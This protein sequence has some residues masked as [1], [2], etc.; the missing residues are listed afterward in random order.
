VKLSVVILC[1]NDLKVLPDCLKSIYAGTH[2]TEFEVIVSDNGSEDGTADYV[3]ENFP[4]VRLIEN[5]ANLRFAKGNNV[6]I[7]VSRG[8]YV[9]ILNPDTII[10]DGALDEMVAYAER[11][12][13]GGAF[14]CRVVNEDGSYQEHVRPL[15]TIRSEWMLTLR[16]G[17]LARFSDWF[18]PGVYVGWNG[19]GERSA[20]QVAG[21]F[22]V[23]RGELLK[24]LGGF[25]E[26]FFYYYE[27]TD[28]C[29]RVWEAGY[30]ILYA[31]DIRITH[32][33]G[34]S[35]K[36]R[37]PLGFTLDRYVTKYRYFYKLEGKRGAE[38]CRRVCLAWLLTRRAGLGLKQLIAPNEDRKLRLEMYKVATEWNWRVD[39]VRL[40]EHG[41]EPEL[42]VQATGR[43]LER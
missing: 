5:G 43:V 24:K 27:D 9:L 13:E 29:R 17:A 25:D 40:V 7:R 31:P 22:L 38:R 15:P 28:L 23:V 32:L 14:S 2:K 21:C 12:P 10:H 34:V 1:W 18:N 19:D 6:G 26:Q 37:Y 36:K 11:H 4:Q 41:E 42:H 8:E 30:S 20:G 35:T 3:R 33:K 39:P 16:L